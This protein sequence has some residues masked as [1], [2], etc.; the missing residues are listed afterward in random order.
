M[1]LFLA[2]MFVLLK[3]MSCDNSLMPVNISRVL[4]EPCHACHPV[5]CVYFSLKRTNHVMHNVYVTKIIK[6]GLVPKCCPSYLSAYLS[7]YL[8]PLKGDIII[9]PT[10]ICI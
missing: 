7:S 5:Y 4:L 6:R 9:N 10:L 1:E 2:P 8:G 3:S